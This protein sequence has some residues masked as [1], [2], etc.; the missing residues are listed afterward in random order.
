MLGQQ[1]ML[2]PHVSMV[3]DGTRN[4][5]LHSEQFYPCV[6]KDLGNLA[7]SRTNQDH[8]CYTVDTAGAEG[9]LRL[10]PVYLDH[11]L[12]PTLKA[13]NST[14]TY[15]DMRGVGL[16]TSILTACCT[17]LHP[18]SSFRFSAMALLLECRTVVL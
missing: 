9:F 13:M 4:I 5:D 6:F 2:R 17:I 11:V 1:Q 15:F 8:T 18:H 7:Q 3:M 12:F 14:L 16:E 10:L